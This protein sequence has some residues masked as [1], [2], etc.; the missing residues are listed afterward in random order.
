MDINESARKQ[1]LMHY[2]EIMIDILFFI[3]DI[4]EKEGRNSNKITATEIVR[5][6]QGKIDTYK[7]YKQWRA[8]PKKGFIWSVP[9]SRYHTMKTLDVFLNGEEQQSV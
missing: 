9:K 5:C 7:K 4:Y 1:K 3:T 6:V 2:K 8:S